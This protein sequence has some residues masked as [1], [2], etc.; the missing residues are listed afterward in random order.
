M[1]RIEL[2]PVDLAVLIRSRWQARVISIL[3]VNRHVTLQPVLLQTRVPI[4]HRVD[5]Q[6][7]LAILVAMPS[8]ST[9]DRSD[10]RNRHRLIQSV[11]SRQR[12]RLHGVR[13]GHLRVATHAR[14]G[15]CCEE[16]LAIARKVLLYVGLP[17]YV[18]VLHACITGLLAL[19]GARPGAEHA[20]RPGPVRAVPFARTFLALFR[21]AG[22]VLATPRPRCVQPNKNPFDERRPRHERPTGTST[23]LLSI[24]GR[25]VA[26]V[27]RNNRLSLR[28]TAVTINTD[29]KHW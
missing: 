24:L 14:I 9:V 5:A 8:G 16:T 12:D 18:L 29:G 3:I 4:R 23:Y 21:V 7:H 22:D 10:S 1:L 20:A 19:H 25:S 26:E 11:H 6:I 13:H 15:S 27:S 2:V 28:C 17:E